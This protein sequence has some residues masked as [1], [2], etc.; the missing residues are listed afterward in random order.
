MK[1][2]HTTSSKAYWR[3]WLAFVITVIVGLPAT[4]SAQSG[5]YPTPA[6]VLAGWGGNDPF[7][8]INDDGVVDAQDLSLAYSYQNNSSEPAPPKL[9][10]GSGFS[11][12]TP[13]PP[14]QGSASLPGYNAKAMARWNFVPHQTFDT[15]FAIGVVAFHAYGINRV[16]FSLNGGPFAAVTQATFNPMSNT[17]EYWATIDPEL[18]ADGEYEVRAVAYPNNGVPRVLAGAMVPGASGVNKGEYSMY[19]VADADFSM[20]RTQRFVSPNGSDTQGN[21]TRA[22]PFQT[23]MKAVHSIH[24]ANGGKADG[25]IVNLLAGNHNYG[26][27][28]WS[29]ISTTQKRWLT[30]RPAPG[31]ASANA[32]IVSATAGGIKLDHVKFERVTF[33]PN[34][35]TN[36]IILTPIG[37]PKLWLDRCV[38]QGVGQQSPGDWQNGWFKSWVTGGSLTGS[39]NGLFGDLIRDLYIDEVGSDAFSGNPLVVN[40]SV[41]RIDA[42]G[43]TFHPDVYQIYLP[44]GVAENFIVYGMRMLENSNTQ[45]LFTGNNVAV[46]DLA[47]VNVTLDTQGY[48]SWPHPWDLTA[49]G[50]AGPTN[51]MLVQDST[52][53]GPALWRTD[54]AFSATDVVL[55]H[56]T[57]SYGGPQPNPL[58]GVT[59]ID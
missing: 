18:L 36:T 31:V 35:S 40:S 4:S 58:S 22:N 46:K 2:L 14:N 42:S 27:Y 54:M 11:A 38:F 8:D 32:P 25:G 5:G 28:S 53:L 48:G 52:I 30:I 55:R 19:F 50:F 57:W 15:E 45:G 49:F 10:A 17:V 7:L 29:Y 24:T 21:G 16:E 59:V 9:V 43:T 51:H 6:Q 33:R 41:R 1:H 47:F 13:Q 12:S 56:N 44:A 3:L 37:Q 26:T 39:A 20:P 34:G 23:I